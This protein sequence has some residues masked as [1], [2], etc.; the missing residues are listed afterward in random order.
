VVA[1]PAGIRISRF[2][3][4]GWPH[5]AR[6]RSVVPDMADSDLQRMKDQEHLRLLV[7]G[8]TVYAGWSAL[9]GLFWLIYVGFGVLFL[10]VPTFAP[11]SHGAAAGPSAQLFGIFFIVIGG[12]AFLFAETLA[13]LNF[14]AARSISRRQRRTLCTVVAALDCLSLPLGT[15]LGVLSLVVLTRASVQA[16]FT[17]APAPVDESRW[18]T[19]A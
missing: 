15:V 18:P 2:G 13:F 14:L 19:P 16:E 1:A 3:G 7:I 17:V 8:H 4:D 6:S 9:L 11:P 10:A 12:I 5:A